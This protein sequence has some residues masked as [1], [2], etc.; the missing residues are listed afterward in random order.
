MPEYPSLEELSE[1]ED[2][3]VFFK[4]YWDS[5]ECLQKLD[6]AFVCRSLMLRWAGL[7]ATPTA[8]EWS[9]F[10]QRSRKLYMNLLQ[11]GSPATFH[12]SWSKV[13]ALFDLVF[14]KLVETESYL[15]GDLP[16][17]I[18]AVVGISRKDEFS[19]SSGCW[20]D[21]SNI[22]TMF[23]LGIGVPRKTREW[24]DFA[25]AEFEVMQAINFNVPQ[26]DTYTCISAML[27]RA[28]ILTMGLYK[29]ELEEVWQT[30]VQKAMDT[31]L[32]GVVANGYETARSILFASLM[33]CQFPLNVAEKLL[34]EAAPLAEEDP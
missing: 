31:V 10:M 27:L 26:T 14:Q 12:N 28:D 30:A 23:E 16:L 7:A 21:L 3:L 1:R 18:T 13:C 17:L 24:K 19:A 34:D 11:R 32:F 8:P 29:Q 2:P 4:N 5:P 15:V 25:K 22:A 6:S 33:E 20:N 9:M